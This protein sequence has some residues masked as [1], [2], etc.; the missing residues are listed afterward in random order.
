MSLTRRLADSLQNLYE[1][2]R[3]PETWGTPSVSRPVFQALRIQGFRAG[4]RELTTR[5]ERVGMPGLS[6]AQKILALVS[7]VCLV[8]LADH[9]MSSEKKPPITHRA[10]RAFSPRAW[11]PAVLLYTFGAELLVAANESGGGG[12]GS[13]RDSDVSYEYTQNPDG[14]WSTKWYNESTEVE[15]TSRPDEG[16]G[17]TTPPGQWDTWDET[18]DPPPGTS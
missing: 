1:A 17:A 2:H 7:G 13:W 4:W 11:K 16:D 3:V 9:F 8:T 18:D 12:G 6:V 15:A 14:S 5:L 10:K